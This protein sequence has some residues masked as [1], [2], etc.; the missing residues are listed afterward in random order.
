MA[1][2]QRTTPLFITKIILGIAIFLGFL[3]I[4][5]KNTD[6][7][8]GWH[9]Q[10][11]Q[12]VAQT[13]TLPPPD[14]YTHTMPGFTWVNHEWLIDAALWWFSAHDLWWLAIVFFSLLTFLPFLIW[15]IR[16]PNFG[17]LWLVLLGATSVTPFIGVRPQMLSFVVFFLVFELLR[18]Y[19]EKGRQKKYLWWLPV[20]FIFW[21]NLHAGFVGGLILFAAYLGIDAV[22]TSLREKKISI[23]EHVFPFA[24]LLASS[25]GTFLNAYGWKMHA[26]IFEAMSSKDVMRYI[27]EFRPLYNYFDVSFILLTGITLIFAFC[28]FRR[29]SPSVLALALLFLVMAG[30][31]SRHWLLFIITAQPFLSGGVAYLSREIAEAQKRKPFL[32]KTISRLRLASIGVFIVVISFFGY[33]VITY[34]GI[35]TPEQAVVFL[36]ENYTKDALR[37]TVLF[38]SYEWGGWLIRE[39]PDL[40]IFIDGRMPYWKMPDGHPLFSDYLTFFKNDGKE[41]EELL[42]RYGITMIM[43]HRTPPQN[44][45]D[46]W[47]KYIPQSIQES[48]KTMFLFKKI[49]TWTEDGPVEDIEQWL[50]E[51]G[52][53]LIYQDGLA[54][55]FVR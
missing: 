20:I 28:F 25:A 9:L 3:T 39:I 47:K 45:D 38:N 49:H 29:Y 37:K 5:I 30:K 32:P 24:I 1:S 40:K 7:D 26:M 12:E 51:H 42:D 19:F 52:W 22:T 31:S 33:K 17:V 2:M 11:G 34:Q 21:A 53:R 36:Q 50:P 14:H 35:Q 27:A 46:F 10:V 4:A 6:P 54:D 18:R 8:M 44:N 16:A 13:W 48:M 23:R 43:L 55:I 41:R 15:V